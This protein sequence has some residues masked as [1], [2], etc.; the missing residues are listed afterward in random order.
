VAARPGKNAPLLQRLRYALAGL[1][2]ALRAERGLRMQV[3]VSLGLLAVLAWT[4]PPAIWWA[5]LILMAVA[6]IAAELVNSA[7]EALAD[8]VA[9]DLHPQVRIVKDCAAA[10]VLVLVVG[11]IAVGLAFLVFLIG[12]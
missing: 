6:V 8:H 9:P 12:R 3:V 1:A 4:R 7:L 5:L 11:A 2:Y 10:A